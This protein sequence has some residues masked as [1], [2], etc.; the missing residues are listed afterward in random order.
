[1]QRI[2]QVMG[3]MNRRGA[4]TFIMNVYRK[5]DRAKFQF[6]FLVYD[7][8]P[9]D[10]EDE[11]VALGGRVLHMPCLP[12][13]NAM[14]S[15]ARIRKII[16]KYG[17]YKAIHIQTLLNS[18]WALIAVRN[19][20]QIKRIVHSHSTNNQLS[21]GLVQ[22]I[23]AYVAK[24]VIRRY[25]QIMLA[26]GEEAGVYL[27]GNRFYREGEVINNGIDLDIHTVCNR[28]AVSAIKQQFGL[29][30][31]L[32]I[33]SVA[34]FNA[35]KNHTFMV[36]IAKC[37]KSKGVD[38]RMLFVGNGNGEN[39]IRQQV[40]EAGL[41]EEVLFV[42]LRNNICDFMFAFDVFLMPSFFE[43]NPVTLI[44]AQAAG[45]PCVISDTITDKIDMGLSLIYKCK[46]SQ[47]AADWADMI[48]Q[49]RHTHCSDMTL[50]RQQL[51]LHGY[52]AQDIAN[53]LTMIYQR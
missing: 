49:V 13:I 7:D 24:A 48:N 18:M 4:E 9:Q 2:L 47:N 28:E 26:C 34:R 35:V 20:H 19:D 45:T 21:I 33:G 22:R 1:M 27:F 11:I 16:Q 40:K 43:G 36:Q 6:D 32:V 30:G 10:Y 25:T 44:E 3:G 29:N 39:A 51:R 37:L 14:F 50:I 23:Y 46:L 41:E 15:V 5:I 52:D 8:L 12:G 42:G 53:N 31:K 38:F 17:P